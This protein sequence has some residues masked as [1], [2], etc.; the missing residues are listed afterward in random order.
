M[1]K[2]VILNEPK[3][4]KNKQNTFYTRRKYI[5]ATA[6]TT[7]FGNNRGGRR[8]YH[9]IIAYFKFVDRFSWLQAHHRHYIPDT[10]ACM[11]RR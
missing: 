4:K 5:D 3:L 8:D 1:S 10:R 2:K 7:M 6:K 9:I 11:H